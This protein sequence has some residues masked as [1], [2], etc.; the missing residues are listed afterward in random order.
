MRFKKSGL[1]GAGMAVIVAAT[2]Q[3]AAQTPTTTVQQD[4]EAAAALDAKGDKAAALAAWE[5]LES[6][7]KPGSRS[8]GVALVRKSAALFKLDRSDDAVI[9]ARGGLALLPAADPRRASDRRPATTLGHRA[10]R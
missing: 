9:A 8:R 7:T 10:Q 1:F 5:K 2:V 3:V 4:F 6:R